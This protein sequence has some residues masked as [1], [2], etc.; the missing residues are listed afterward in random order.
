MPCFSPLYLPPPTPSPNTIDVYLIGGQSNATSQGYLANL[1][2]G[3]TPDQRVLLF[4]SGLPHFKRDSAFTTLRHTAAYGA[5]FT[6]VVTTPAGVTLR[7]ALLSE[8]AT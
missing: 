2:P 4:N 8:S 5:V 6:T 7:I 3:F 1:P